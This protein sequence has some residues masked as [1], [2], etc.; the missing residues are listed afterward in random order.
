M[1]RVRKPL[2]LVGSAT[3]AIAAVLLAT[4]PRMARAHSAFVNI[5]DHDPE[6]GLYQGTINGDG[7]IFQPGNMDVLTP[8]M[9]FLNGISG[10]DVVSSGAAGSVYTLDPNNG[11]P[12]VEA[13]AVALQVRIGTGIKQSL[14]ASGDA[15]LVASDLNAIPQGLF[16]VMAYPFN[17]I[18]PQ[19]AA[20]A[21]T[22]AA[23]EAALSTGVDFVTTTQTT[24]FGTAAL[25]NLSLAGE[26]G[27]QGLFSK[28]TVT[29]VGV[30]VVPEPHATALLGLLALPIA[31]RRSRRY[32]SR[33]STNSR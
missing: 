21:A 33:N 12:T 26:L 28:V 1:L 22:L 32:A 4:C 14:L 15:A 7:H 19:Y 18:P 31:A 2:D 3:L 16:P 27:T 25:W 20:A 6:F 23:G 5:E 11:A 29:D 24:G 30:T 9:S 8:G 17:A 13:F 10:G